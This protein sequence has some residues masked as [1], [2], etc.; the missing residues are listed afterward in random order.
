MVQ[1]SAIKKPYHLLSG[2]ITLDQGEDLFDRLLGL[3]VIYLD[4]PLQF[5]RPEAPFK[6]KDQIK[7]PRR[8]YPNEAVECT[9]ASWFENNLVGAEAKAEFSKLLK[10]WGGHSNSSNSTNSATLIRR[11]EIPENPRDLVQELLELQTYKDGIL[12]MARSQSQGDRPVSIGIIT[13]FI[14][15]VN[16]SVNKE[17]EK[18]TSGGIQSTVPSDVMASTTNVSLS[19]SGKK[20]NKREIKGT[21]K[22]EVV[23]ACRY[24]EVVVTP[25]PTPPKTLLNRARELFSNPAPTLAVNSN[26]ID[27]HGSM[28]ESIETSYI[29]MPGDMDAPFGSKP[30]G[31]RKDRERSVKGEEQ[32]QEE[33][34]FI[35]NM[36]TRK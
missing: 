9:D 28:G 32:E 11:V 34:D 2:V 33:A 35:I 31:S 30:T 20:L 17:A 19:I 8:L 12:D 23:L 13:G 10:L 14:S 36:A 1:R 18:D 21:Y 22:G 3:A 29:S 15:C 5:V 6:P 27:V 4:S 16:M 7:E 25:T 26:P 24:H